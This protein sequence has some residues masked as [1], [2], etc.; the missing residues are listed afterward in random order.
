MQKQLLTLI[1][2]FL[3]AAACFA[4]TYTPEPSNRVVINLGETPW[5]FTKT[6]VVGGQNTSYSDASWKDVG[7]PHTYDDTGTFVNMSMGGNDGTVMPGTVWYRKHFTLD[8]AYSGRKVFVEFGGVHVGCQVYI[9]GTFIPGNS[10][11]NPNATHVIGFVGF[12]VDITANVQFGGAD[13]VLA[14]RV[15]KSQGF[16]SDPGFAQ[17]FRFGQSDGG[18]FRPVWLHIT[19]KVHVPLNVYSVVNQWGT[20]VATNTAS[21][22]SA[23]VRIMTNVQNEGA[24]AASV[25]LTTKV[26]DY[27]NAGNVVLSL[28]ATQTIAAGQA[29]VFDQ[30]G[31]IANP[32]LWYPNNSAYGTPYM[33]KVYHIVKVGGATV[34]VFETPT[35]FRVLTW[36]NNF[37]IFNGHQHYLWGASSR[38]DY[39]ALGTAVPEEQQWRDAKLCADAGG[40]LWRPGHSTC[41]S[42]FVH[43]CDNYGIMIV[44]PT[45]DAEGAFSGVAATDPKGVLKS[46]LHRDMVIRDRNDPSILAYETDNGGI[47]ADLASALKTISAQWD[48]VHTRLHND[49]TGNCGLGD[50]HSCTASGCEM[51]IKSG[52]PTMPAFGAEAWNATGMSARWAYDHQIA[53]VGAYL[54]NWVKSRQANCFGLC[55]WYFAETVGEA[56]VY[57]ERPAGDYNVRSFGCSMMDMNR[58]PKLLYYAYQAAWVPFSSKPVVALAHHWNRSG[59]VRVNAFSNCP[60]VRLR[61]NGADQGTKTPNPWTGTGSDATETSTQLPMQCSWDVAWAAGTLLAEGLD[62]NGNVVCTDQR[63]TAGE[64]DHITLTVEPP[65]VKP[66]GGTFVITANGSDAAFVLATVVDANN[67]WCPLDSHNITFGVSGPGNYRGGSDQYVTVG[68]PLSYHSP[69]DPELRAEGGMCKVA[70]RSMFTAGTVT[71]TATSPGLGQAAVSFMV[72]PLGTSVV[73][74]GSIKQATARAT[75]PV[76]KTVMAGGK[77]RYFISIPGIVTLTVLDASG[78]VLKNIPGSQQVYGWHQ[79]NL[80]GANGTEVRNGV[81]FVRLMVNGKEEGTRRVI[82]LP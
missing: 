69:L 38:Y 34:D 13:N 76:F 32:H 42:E 22:A 72:Y 33:Y 10:A 79:A 16:Y 51:G 5:K 43:A 8:N 4:E 49:R 52:C 2:V 62:A 77:L 65:L 40:S 36:D 21:D 15:G 37:P 23:N 63:V 24:A 73:A 17:G 66:D 47:T 74:G 75:T 19:D 39:P 81:Y 67:N 50:I 30:S 44:Q 55:Q 59:A 9:N 58:I 11:L 48:P 6:D 80:A 41:S 29:Y 78:R 57:L 20:Y 3:V 27:R 18:I 61:I 28:T 26:V 45:G 71:V 82:L 7:V 14:V 60:S 68:Q 12:V 53:Y 64:P 54:P 31:D 56:G 46:E 35:G 1:S 25:S 70:V